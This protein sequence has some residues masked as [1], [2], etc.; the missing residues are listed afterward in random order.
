[1]L[2]LETKARRRPPGAGPRSAAG[3]APGAE[4]L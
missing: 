3:P 1:M 4:V 2:A